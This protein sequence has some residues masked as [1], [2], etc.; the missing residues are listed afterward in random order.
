MKNNYQVKRSRSGL[1]LFAKTPIKKG[2]FIIEY[3]G[4]LVKEKDAAYGRYLFSVN[5][6]WVV[7]GSGRKNLARYINHS[8]RPNCEPE[9]E[10]KRIMI[11]AKKNIKPGEELNYDY[12]KEYFDEY[13]KPRGCRCRRCQE[14]KN[15][16]SPNLLAS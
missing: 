1:G 16:S 2:D 5:S 4:K 8:C 7:D 14:K 11:Y 9:I 15:Q 12:G 10:G 13:I 6:R 3:R